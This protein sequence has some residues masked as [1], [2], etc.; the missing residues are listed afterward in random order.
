MMEAYNRGIASWKLTPRWPIVLLKWLVVLLICKVVVSILSNYSGYFPP[1]FE[2]DFLR[3]RESHFFGAYRFAFFT[4]IVA[5]P[6]VLIT[7]LLLLSE[8]LRRRFPVFHRRLGTWHVMTVLF[9]VAPSGLGM[10][11]FADTGFIAGL[12]FAMLA[13]ATG[14]CAAMGW[15]AAVMHRFESHRRWMLRC[16]MLL[17]SA[18]LLR[19]FSGAAS[20]INADPA[21]T[22][23]LAAWIT[24]TVPW[25]C[26]EAFEYRSD[27][28][29]TG[30]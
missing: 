24:W 13:I 8:R 25:I 18:V 1:N 11:A 28:R 22:Y 20:L 30:G 27:D 26:F 14:F 5:S 6:C 16:Y 19:L 9:L 10:S 15:R 23:P 21:W 4:H 7:G 29:R 12:G 3:G 2:T 17:C